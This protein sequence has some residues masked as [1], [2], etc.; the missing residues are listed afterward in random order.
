MSSLMPRIVLPIAMALLAALL[1]GALGLG[2][3]GNAEAAKGILALSAMALGAAVIAAL[4]ALRR[5]VTRPLKNLADQIKRAEA[6]AFLARASTE[7]SQPSEIAELSAAFNATL[8]T[9]T[10]MQVAE[11]ETSFQMK[12]MEGE[13]LLKAELESQN[14]RIE[15]ANAELQQRVREMTLLL[16]VAR[17]LGSTLELSEILKDVTEL[18]GVSM[19]VDQFTVMLLE[20]DGTLQIAASFG[21]DAA[22]CASFRLKMGEGASGIAAQ[23]REPVYITDIQTDPRFVRGPDDPETEA[24]LLCVPMLCRDRFVG[25]LNFTRLRKAAFSDSDIVLLQLMASQAALAVLNAQLYARM[26]ELSLIDPHTGCFNRRHL[27]DRLDLELLRAQRLSRPLA[28]IMIEVDHC[29]QI[30]DRHGE[31]AGLAI[32]KK[33]AQILGS[34]IRSTDAVGRYDGEKFLVALPNCAKREAQTFAEMLRRTVEQSR[35]LA[36]GGDGQAPHITLSLGIAAYPEDAEAV[37]RLVGAAGAALQAARDAGQNRS[38]LFCQE[39][40][41]RA[42]AAG[43]AP[44]DAGT[45]QRAAPPPDER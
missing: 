43:S 15:Q 31:A 36:V 23:T 4:V 34:S 16:D 11:I 35:E 27:L 14:R 28:A 17:Q 12:Q 9:I 13:L 7:A 42:E 22:R 6:G 18:V 38:V 24:S 26:R 1:L 2:F 19:G 44:P 40:A 33:V 25:I 45:E 20:P 37:E 21:L 39:V 29:R 41:A 32:L 10:S 8:A 5:F 3:F 30:A